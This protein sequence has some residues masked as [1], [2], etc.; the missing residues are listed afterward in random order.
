MTENDWFSFD[1]NVALLERKTFLR[2]F[3]G[4][5]INSQGIRRHWSHESSEVLSLV[6]K[7]YPW[8]G[9]IC[10]LCSK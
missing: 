5:A 1:G 2:N 3:L 7:K 10:L 4:R 9:N 8:D 6:M